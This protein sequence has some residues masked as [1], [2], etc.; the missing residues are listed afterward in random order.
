MK[1]QDIEIENEVL[2]QSWDK[3]PSDHLDSYLVSD[4]EDP[5]I[6]IHSILTRSL[7]VDS[8]F[9]NVYSA[10][11]QEELRFG[12]IMTWLLLE[13][14]RG[15]RRT[16]LF[17]DIETGNSTTVPAFV[18]DAASALKSDRWTLP[19][20]ITMVVDFRN[21]DDP[22]NWLC[23]PSKDVFRSLWQRLLAGCPQTPIRVFE[24][25]CGSANDYRA[26]HQCGLARLIQYT[27]LEISRR[28]V[29]NALDRF[30]NVDFRCGSILDSGIPSDVFDYV[31]VHDLLEH[32]SGEAIELTVTE[33]IRVTQREVWLH[34]FNSKATGEHDVVRVR[35]YHWNTIS[36]KTL[37]DL[38]Q[39]LGCQTEIVVIAD[40]LRDKFGYQ[41][42]YNQKEATVILKKRVADQSLS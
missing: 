27:G 17:V 11:I 21:L 12:A 39:S 26:I 34:L 7:L 37:T 2:R 24:P 38:G 6:N 14:K 4:V 15:R 18:L 9:P 22:S 29:A 30:P 16:D 23:D 20:Y 10:L 1:K 35:D 25:A 8:L 3:H 19:D 40:M 36:C 31:F 28:N 32:L 42:Y 41:N 33:I 13:L 5:R